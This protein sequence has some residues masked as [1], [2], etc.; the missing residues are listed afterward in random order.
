MRFL[1]APYET[2]ELCGHKGDEDTVVLVAGL[3]NSR[4]VRCA[5]YGECRRRWETVHDVDCWETVPDVV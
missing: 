1:P 2:C 4:V 3:I 5:N